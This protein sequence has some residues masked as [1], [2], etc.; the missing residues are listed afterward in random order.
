MLELLATGLD[1]S[2]HLDVCVFACALI[3]FWTQSQLGEML[4]KTQS[5][6]KSPQEVPTL[7]DL[8]DPI[9]DGGSCRLFL[10]KTKTTGFKGAD[11]FITAQH[12][13]INPIS[14]L[15][16]HIKLNSPPASVSILQIT[17]MFV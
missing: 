2:L 10:L 1:L 16:A 3:T 6:F 7:T 13:S 17:N 9:T 8:H 11:T 4:S 5:K 12:I 15:D 14:A